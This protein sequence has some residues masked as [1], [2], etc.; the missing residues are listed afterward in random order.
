VREKHPSRSSKAIKGQRR[1]AEH[2]NM[3]SDALAGIRAQII[4]EQSVSVKASTTPSGD[5][6]GQPVT[7]AMT[8]SLAMRT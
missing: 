4:G 1:N 8:E 2:K 6:D 7:H 3:V 5:N